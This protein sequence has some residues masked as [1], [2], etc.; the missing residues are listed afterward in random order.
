MLATVDMSFP[1]SS[2][3]LKYQ[4]RRSCGE[5]CAMPAAARLCRRRRIPPAENRRWSDPA[6]GRGPAAGNGLV[7]V[8]LCVIQLSMAA[9]VPRFL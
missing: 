8:P 5:Q 1:C 9:R 3:V 7:R 2:K 4:G 6:R